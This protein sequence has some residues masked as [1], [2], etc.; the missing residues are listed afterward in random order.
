[1]RWSIRR[2]CAAASAVIAVSENTAEDLRHLLRLPDAKIRVIHEAPT[3]GLTPKPVPSR[4]HLQAI[5]PALARPYILVVG[6]I[7][8]RKRLGLLVEAYEM[9]RRQSTLSQALVVVGKVG[10]K[11]EASLHAMRRSAEAAFIH[12]LDYVPPDDLP[13]LYRGADLFVMASRYEGF[14]L[15]PLEAMACGT[16]VVVTGGGSLAE[17]VGAGGLVVENASPQALAQAMQ[18]ILQDEGL[19]A[20]WRDRGLLRQARFSW[21]KTA[22]RTLEL[23]EELAQR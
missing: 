7:E 3:E 1:M 20:S 4:E 10:W 9:L 17:V 15:P 6:T 19:R 12:H 21:K 13:D 18:E 14:G 22:E 23:Y 5:H 8:P 2:S 16:P 11:A